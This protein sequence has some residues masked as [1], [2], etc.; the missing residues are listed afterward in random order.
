[1]RP[2]EGLVCAWIGLALALLVEVWMVRGAAAND[3]IIR[4]PADSWIEILPLPDANP[5][6]ADQVQDGISYLLSE[7]Q[8]RPIDGGRE[9]YDRLAYRVVDR[10]GL[11]NGA[12]I[13]FEFDP[14]TESVT[15]NRLQIV[16]DGVVLD[17][18]DTARIE[19]ARR[20]AD[21]DS[22]IF[23]GRLT[24]YINVEDVRVGDIIDRARTTI[25]KPVIG[26]ALEHMNFS[27]EWGVPVAR[28]RI[29]AVWPKGR[30]LFHK[31]REVDLKPTIEEQGASTIYVW[32]SIDAPPITSQTD[33]PPGFPDQG[34]IDI[35][36]TD[37]WQDVV[38]ATRPH[39]RLDQDLPV[40]F[41]RRIDQ[42]AASF[43]KPEDRLVEILRLIQDDIRYVSLAIG[44]GSHIPRSPSEVVASGFGDC[45]DKSLLL[46]ISLRRLG[47]DAEVALTDTDEGLALPD[48]LP[49]IGLF[50]HMIVK[51]QIGRD[52]Y[53]LDPT[54]YL[55]GGR[56]EGL[57]PPKFNYAL[58]FGGSD[59]RL[60]AIPDK[61]LVLPTASIL[62]TFDF[63]T[64][65]GSPLMLGVVT[66]YRGSGADS[67][68]YRLKRKSTRTFSEDYLKYYDG[69]YPGIE[70]AA[71]LTVTDD[72]DANVVIVTEK[73]RLS[74]ANLLADDLIKKFPLQA[75]IG[76]GD[77]PEP[78]KVGRTAP[79]WLGRRVL[80][81]HKVVVRNLKA[82]FG[83]PPDVAEKMSPYAKMTTRTSATETQLEVM[84]NF[85]TLSDRIP[86]AYIATYLRT[87][88]DMSSNVK[89]TYDFTYTAPKTE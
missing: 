54:D 87:L 8:F 61:P 43:P 28:H 31:A 79:V 82:R 30:P 45:K 81:Q 18:L 15:L 16:R 37:R 60:E 13:S 88:D 80:K 42:L 67:M 75:D 78:S 62:E 26:G 21:A 7:F 83:P 55:Q 29:K 47:I 56:A 19:I 86:A 5:A 44:T 49:G 14:G 27:V 17:R 50:D 52:V 71:A 58:P 48:R 23:D 59:A 20:E 51:A 38:D 4:Q 46:A 10:T 53:W 68:R 69:L 11:D 41:A 35:S 12:R 25:R 74:A 72:R 32:D 24:A 36:S 63:P 57:V 76:V 70:T 33:L 65:E 84:W 2:R 64:A 66:T 34:N 3:A 39:Y 40:D 77:L 6:F 1:M 89:W 85:A 9:L 73:Y 22:G